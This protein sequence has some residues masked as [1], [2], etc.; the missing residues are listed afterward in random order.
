MH[1]EYLIK[2]TDGDWFNVHRDDYERTL[3]PKS[4]PWGVA[5]DSDFEYCIEISGC[6]V[7]FSYED[8]GILVVFEDDVFSAE[9]ELQLVKEMLENLT[10]LKGEAGEVI[11]L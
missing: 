8:P 2:R 3:V 6:Q 4:L 7:S 9:E 5:T 1:S 11:P 10:R